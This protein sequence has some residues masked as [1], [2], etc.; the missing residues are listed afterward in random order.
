MSLTHPRQGHDAAFKHRAIPVK[1][2]QMRRR[3]RT[4]ALLRSCYPH[5][6]CLA[7]CL[8]RQLLCRAS[9]QLCLKRYHQSALPKSATA[10]TCT[11]S[12]RLLPHLRKKPCCR[13]EILPCV[14]MQPSTLTLLVDLP[15]SEMR[16]CCIHVLPAQQVA[17]KCSEGCGAPRVLFRVTK[18]L[19]GRQAIPRSR[20]VDCRRLPPGTP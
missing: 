20:S 13:S 7:C 11:L 3:P 5:S 9:T 17:K 8:C 2:V 18:T 16:P 6:A 14:Q 10:T 4:R 15:V 1:A 19:V 12:T